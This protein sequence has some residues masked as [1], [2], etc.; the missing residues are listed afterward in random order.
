MSELSTYP[1]LFDINNFCSASLFANLCLAPLP[2]LELGTDYVQG[3]GSF[4]VSASKTEKT[5]PVAVIRKKTGV[6]PASFSLVIQ[7]I[8]QSMSNRG[9]E[10]IGINVLDAI[11]TR[12]QEF[13]QIVGCGAIVNGPIELTDETAAAFDQYLGKQRKPRRVFKTL[14]HQG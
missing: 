2:P 13:R 4:C 10:V 11:T 6:S 8:D 3:T 12:P 1:V 9:S 5:T 7:S 14:S